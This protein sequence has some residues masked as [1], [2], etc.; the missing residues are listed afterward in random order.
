M[1]CA[2]QKAGA[3][4]LVLALLAG[5]AVR[6]L[7]LG[8]LRDA[9]DLAH[10]G[11]DAGYHAWW[12]RAI[13]TG[14]WTPPPDHA[15]PAFAR[16]PYF[17]PPG[18][19]WLL[20][21]LHVV[22][23]GH[24]L[25]L[26]GA[27]MLMGLA[28]V[29]L[30]WMFVRRWWG[31]FP[32]AVT[33]WLSATYWV[34]VY[35]E[36]ELLEPAW[37]VLLTWGLLFVLGLWRERP[38]DGLAAASGLLVGLIGITR[39]N[40][41]LVG[42]AMAGWMLAA[43]RADGAGWRA[44]F[45][46]VALAAL[47]AVLC[48]LPVTARNWIAARDLVLVSANG[49]IN[50]LM[51]QDTEAIAD[52]A[53][54]ATGHWNCFDFP[55]LLARA[56]AEAGRPLRASELSAQH[57]REAWRI[58]R[59]DPGGTARRL[60]LKTLLF[61][62]PREVS[63]NKVEELERAHSRVLRALPAPFAWLAG[64]GVLG[65]VLARGAAP[66]GFVPRALA[67]WMLL[68]A[69]VCFASVLPFIA[70][71]QYRVPVLPVLIAGSGLAAGRVFAL[72]RGGRPGIALALAAAGV[73]LSGLFS[74]NAAGY[75]VQPARWHLARAIAY[76]RAGN[77]AG[78]ERAYRA[79]LEQAPD[80]ELGPLRLG[81]LLAKQDRV[82]EA[83]PLFEQ[84]QALKPGDPAIRFNLGLALAVLGRPAEA[85]PHF[86]SVVAADPARADAHQNLAEALQQTGDPDRAAEHRRQA[87][88]LRRT[89]TPP[90]SPH[91]R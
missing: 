26:R 75:R 20:G 58:I 30:G 19:P 52:H 3:L 62:G 70:A 44:V 12:A 60:L 67:G 69:L 39:P 73:A 86:E 87:A 10:P 88:L 11:L 68:F 47:A 80:L 48:V 13:A 82:A 23:G 57:R 78:A 91:R 38:R 65:L 66:A 41:L 51:G 33:A 89:Q 85:V 77:A 4:F 29:V 56:S 72:A 8:E 14:D 21:A 16:H 81:A 54:E 31:V 28:S 24:P 83:L 18:Y 53:S 74:V 71:G 45:R 49:G 61:W 17:R 27:Q 63:N 5:A 32:A 36:G 9:P 1:F 76:E 50:L 79:V 2:M 42:P 7:Y 6:L 15:D 34:L 25:A 40:L 35:Y 84:A 46:P 37:L 64:W 59:T 55:A 43:G 22:T 90:V